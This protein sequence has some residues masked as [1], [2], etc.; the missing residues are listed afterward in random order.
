[1][2]DTNG[3]PIQDG[4]PKHL[5]RARRKRCVDDQ[6]RIRDRDWRQAVF[7][8]AKLQIKRRGGILKTDIL[9]RSI[10]ES[11]DGFSIG[12]K[13]HFSHRIPI[14]EQA[15]EITAQ[16]AFHPT[17]G[18]AHLYL[19]EKGFEFRLC[20]SVFADRR[21]AAHQPANFVDGR[22]NDGNRAAQSVVNRTV[23]ALEQKCIV[24]HVHPFPC[25][26]HAHRRFSVP[27]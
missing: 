20:L 26:L 9:D 13:H 11:C 24:P 23:A 2:S 27:Q 25:G 21:A 8:G 19:P 7:H 18:S 1:M 10:I 3:Q 12:G 6:F 16:K 14:G 5:P 4:S 15:V 17:G 22:V